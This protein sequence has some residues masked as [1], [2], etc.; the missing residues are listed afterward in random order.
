MI[1]SNNPKNWIVIDE[2]KPD[3]MRMNKDEIFAC[4]R[5]IIDKMISVGKTR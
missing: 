2:I 1:A 5:P 4:V 3:G